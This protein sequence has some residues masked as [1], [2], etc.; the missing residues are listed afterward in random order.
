[1]LVFHRGA[2][3]LAPG[4]GLLFA[5]AMNILTF[6]IFGG[7]YY[8]EHQWPK[9]TVLLAAGVACLGVGLLI[10]RKRER[11]F[12]R[13]QQAIDALSQRNKTANA[14]AFSGP[15]DHLMFIPLQYWSIVYFVGAVIYIL[16]NSA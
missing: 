9:V 11:D 12:S 4:F 7:S 5:L 13:E 15:R 8:E 3:I 16:L 1:M 14:A 6:R 10:K 2:G